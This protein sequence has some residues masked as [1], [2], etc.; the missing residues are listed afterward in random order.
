LL[1]GSVKDAMPGTIDA[2]VPLG[3]ILTASAM[4]ILFFTKD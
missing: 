1:F 2:E 3:F 4:G